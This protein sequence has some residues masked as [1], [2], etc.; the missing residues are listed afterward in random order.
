M[1]SASTCGLLFPRY[2]RKRTLFMEINSGPMWTMWLAKNLGGTTA[3]PLVRPS[4]TRRLRL[5]A[6]VSQVA[7]PLA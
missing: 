7:R 6:L 1:K 5:R 2:F 4:T 3:P